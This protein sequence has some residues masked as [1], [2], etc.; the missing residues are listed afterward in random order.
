MMLF[1]GINIDTVSIIIN[2]LSK[3]ALYLI[4]NS[5]VLRLVKIYRL[6]YSHVNIEN[7]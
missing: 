7:F 5:I 4:Q 1:E 6:L 3:H 2:D